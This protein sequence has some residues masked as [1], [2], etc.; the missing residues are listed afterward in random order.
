MFSFAWHHG[1][2]RSVHAG[3]VGR[4]FGVLGLVVW[5]GLGSPRGAAAQRTGNFCMQALGGSSCTAND[6]SVSSFTVVSVS[7]PCVNTSGDTGTA[8]F[9]I[10]QTVAQ[11]SRY[12]L[13]FTIGL[14]GSATGGFDG[15]SCYHDYLPGPVAVAAPPGPPYLDDDGNSCGDGGTTTGVTWLRTTQSITFTCKDSDSDGR[16][17]LHVCNSWKQNAAACT[18]VAGA[19][20]GTGSKCRCDTF[21]VFGPLAVDVTGFS[22]EADG[23]AGPL[24]QALA[25]ALLGAAAVLGLGRRWAWSRGRGAA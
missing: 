13:G 7:D 8:V 11:S 10:G 17:D 24:T 20:P 5:A 1:V 6:I 4:I 12:D 3:R 15:G 19:V 25:I 21:D 18:D 23:G 14:T 2:P 16:Y 9:N 22:A